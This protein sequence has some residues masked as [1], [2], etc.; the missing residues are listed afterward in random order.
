MIVFRGQIAKDEVEAAKKYIKQNFDK[1][2]ELYDQ[3]ESTRKSLGYSSSEATRKSAIELCLKIEDLKKRGSKTNEIV[4]NISNCAVSIV[5]ALGSAKDD[6]SLK[7]MYLDCDF[8]NGNSQRFKSLSN[9][10]Y[11]QLFKEISKKESI[12]SIIYD[13]IF[14][15]T[16]N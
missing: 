11:L 1:T 5:Y 9:K 12:A 13:P 2:I 16:H 10:D 4:S 7:D 15:E 6:F 14:Q 8:V 3:A